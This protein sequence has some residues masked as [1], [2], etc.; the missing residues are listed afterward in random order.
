MGVFTVAPHRYGRGILLV[1]TPSSHEGPSCWS[2]SVLQ[3]GGR[4]SRYEM[5]T[6][7]DTIALNNHLQNQ[8]RLASLSWVD[9]T[10]GPAHAP[11]WTSICK[12]DGVVVCEGVGPHKHEARNDAARKALRILTASTD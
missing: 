10:R 11:E 4:P 7:E 2:W 9:E 8:G 1:T 3:G 12:I 5:S 6:T